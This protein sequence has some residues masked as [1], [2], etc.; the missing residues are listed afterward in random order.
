MLPG[1]GNLLCIPTAIR[2]ESGSGPPERLMLELPK[3]VLD[4]L[5]LHL[6]STMDERIASSW[7]SA[8]RGSPFTAGS[9]REGSIACFAASTPSAVPTFRRTDA[10]SRR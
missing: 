6:V 5:K 4:A 3:N 1:V 7:R 9:H 8:S 10:T 2:E